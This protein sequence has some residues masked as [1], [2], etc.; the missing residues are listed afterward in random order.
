MRDPLLRC[1]SS[2]PSST[3]SWFLRVRENLRQLFT[4]VPLFPSSANGAPIHLLEHKGSPRIIRAQT[5]SLLTHAAM[6]AVLAFAAMHLYRSAK[7]SGAGVTRV[8]PHWRL[9]RE[10]GLRPDAGAGS[11]GRRTPI[12]TTTGD[13]V[14]AYSIQLV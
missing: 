11:G 1:L 6:I 10:V 4:A 3:D 13:L 2:L 5:V 7:P 14:P 9:A 8:Q 12:P